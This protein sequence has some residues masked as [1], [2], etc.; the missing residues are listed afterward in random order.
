MLHTLPPP[1][2]VELV[3]G[4]GGGAGGSGGEG[5]GRRGGVEQREK[6][7]DILA[8]QPDRENELI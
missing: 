4:G 5:R 7:E 8:T 2:I 3:G 6:W 1:P